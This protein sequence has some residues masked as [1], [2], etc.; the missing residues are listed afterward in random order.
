MTTRKRSAFGQASE[1]DDGDTEVVERE[2]SYLSTRSNTLN[3]ISG[4]EIIEKVHRLVDPARCKISEYHDR[5]YSLLNEHNCEDLI[6]G[7]LEM[8]KQE[9]AAIVRRLSGDPD[10]DWE[11]IAGARR[12][13]T[14]SY[15][16][17]KNRPE[18]KFLIEERQLT[19]EE[20]F[21]LSDIEN[22]NNKDISDYERA[23]KYKRALSQ[24]YSSQK[25]MAKRM[26]VS[27]AWL[28][29]FLDLASLPNEVV[30]AF[31][32]I[33]DIKVE[34]GKRLKPLLKDEKN[35][36]KILKRAVELLAEKKK[37]AEKGSV[38]SAQQ[39]VTELVNSVKDIKGSKTESVELK[40]KSGA[41][42][43]SAVKKG[44]GTIVLNVLPESGASKTE[45][46]TAFKKV[47]DQLY[48]K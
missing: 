32:V 14:V 13:W 21:R 26:E 47:I 38:I 7:F 22:R 34:H 44:K 10:Y 37:L 15:L 28:S 1:L 4:G 19:D 24:F 36:T 43:M 20:A 25:D 18:F 40:S 2:S 33:T 29:R 41:S 12:H 8:G 16:R 39:V 31:P 27:E 46:V 5:E 9:F 23:R 30:N 11:V 35:S 3:D 42:M 17:S 45:L 48:A 6:H